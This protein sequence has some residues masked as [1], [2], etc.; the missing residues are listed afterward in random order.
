VT[1]AKNAVNSL[2]ARSSQLSSQANASGGR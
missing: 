1:K 2:N